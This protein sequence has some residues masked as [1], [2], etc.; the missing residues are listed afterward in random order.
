M[1]QICDKGLSALQLAS[2]NVIL[3]KCRGPIVFRDEACRFRRLVLDA[4][5][6]HNALLLD[7]NDV[8]TID[9]FG[10]GT[11]VELHHLAQ[12]T[13]KILRVGSTSPFVRQVLAITNLDRVCGAK[14]I[15]EHVAW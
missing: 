7:L 5:A 6:I 14:L 10:V 15:W 12:S 13:N 8:P 1:T 11:L 9:A 4:F 2:K 3:V